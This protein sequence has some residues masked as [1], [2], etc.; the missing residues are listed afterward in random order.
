VGEPIQGVYHSFFRHHHLS[1]DREAG[2]GRFVADVNMLFRRNALAFEITLAGEARRLLPAPLADTIGWMLFQ[3]GD[4]ETD[5]LLEAARRR[6]LSPKPEDRIPRRRFCMES[7]S[8]SYCLLGVKALG[9]VDGVDEDADETSCV[10]DVLE[11]AAVDFFGLEGLHETL[12]FGIVVRIAGPAHADGDIVAGEALAIIG[13]SIL[14]TIGM[15][16]AG[17]GLR[18]ASA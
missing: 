2:L 15:R 14:A 8:A 18:S 1:W 17:L 4:A 16:L 3:T 7:G 10:L 13:R 5:R 9:V 11:A 12:G 6:I